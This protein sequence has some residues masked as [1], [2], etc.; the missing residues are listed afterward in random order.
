MDKLTSKITALG[1]APPFLLGSTLPPSRPS[2]AAS[3]TTFAFTVNTAF[4]TRTEFVASALQCTDCHLR[5]DTIVIATACAL[6]TIVT[7]CRTHRTL[8]SL[9][10]PHPSHSPASLGRMKCR[11]SQA[12]R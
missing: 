9:R 8:D 10:H 3:A 4:P 11:F 5:L 12:G 1:L 6:D 2:P 7:R